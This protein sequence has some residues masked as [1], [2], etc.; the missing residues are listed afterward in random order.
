[1]TDDWSLLYIVV[2]CFLG[3]SYIDRQEA[4]STSGLSTIFRGYVKI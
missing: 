4:L 1:M 2:Q 3:S